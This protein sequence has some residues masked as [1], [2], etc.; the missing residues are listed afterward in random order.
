MNM[1]NFLLESGSHSKVDI[2]VAY[3]TVLDMKKDKQL[4]HT[5]DI[6]I[7]KGPKFP[8]R[9]KDL[10]IKIPLKKKITLLVHTGF[11]T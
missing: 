1:G 5:A 7:Y 4:Q 3:K 8:C 10:L 6:L 11:Y 9:Y 2:V